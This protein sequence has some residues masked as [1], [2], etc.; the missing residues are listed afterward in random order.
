MNRERKWRLPT[1]NFPRFPSFFLWFNLSTS[2]PSVCGVDVC[3]TATA[4]NRDVMAFDGV[5]YFTWCP[6][7]HQVFV[8]PDC[9][10]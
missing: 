1:A 5:R 4:G 6:F 7:R 3:I 9:S 10:E 2:P 8:D